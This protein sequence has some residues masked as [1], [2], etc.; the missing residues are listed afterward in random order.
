[1]T[2]VLGRSSYIDDITHGDPT[3]D[4]LCEDLNALLYL[5]RY[6]NISVS[7]PKGEFGKLTTRYLS[8]EIS[9]EDTRAMPKIAKS[10]QELPFPTTLKVAAA[11]H[12]STH[13]NIKAGRDLSTAKKSFEFLKRKIVSTPL[14]GHPDRNKPFVIIPHANRWAVCAVLG[15]EYD[16]KILPV[17]LTCWVL[18]E[19]EIKY[20][21]AE[22]EVIAI[23]RV[24]NVVENL[25]REC[26]IKVYTRYSVLSWLL[27][28]KSADGRCDR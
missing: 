24:L 19:T 28:A 26:P 18:N 2:P 21:E 12:E 13:E 5:L 3:W 25:V 6:W 4:Q 22:E 16:G 7:L 14:L 27:K 10:V 8:H 17:R 20:H 15:Q 9:A 11:L 23:M 1:M